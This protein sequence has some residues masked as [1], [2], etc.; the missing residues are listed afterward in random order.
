MRQRYKAEDRPVASTCTEIIPPALEPLADVA[1]IGLINM[2]V[3]ERGEDSF[4]RLMPEGVRVFTTRM[5]VDLETYNREG[6]F[7]P[8]GGLDHVARTLPVPNRL[9]LIAFSCTSGAI[10]SGEAEVAG[11]FEG[12][13]PGVPVTNPAT[14]AALGLREAGVERFALLTPYVLPVHAQLRPFFEQRGFDVTADGTFNAETHSDIYSI[15]EQSFVDAG[16]QLLAKGGDALFL[17]CTAFDVVDRLGRLTAILGVPVFSSTQL[18]AWHALHIL[19]LKDDA[20]A[21]LAR[22]I[23]A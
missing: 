10:A 2:W 17:S 14:A 3:D 11:S 18:F 16:R 5:C 4:T 23:Q 21:I 1:R 8:L 15:S 6:R 13:H 9:D 7:V 20:R 12:V 19:G 22:S